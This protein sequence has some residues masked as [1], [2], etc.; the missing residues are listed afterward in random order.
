MENNIDLNREALLASL[1]AEIC[2]V[3][4]TKKDG[5]ERTMRCTRD[6]QRA[7]HAPIPKNENFEDNPD[8]IRAYDLEAE[9]WRS[10][11]VANVK[12]ATVLA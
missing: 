5:T 11:I 7:L 4:F 10:F 6:L 8:V 9:G 12:S 1:G 3:V 2:K